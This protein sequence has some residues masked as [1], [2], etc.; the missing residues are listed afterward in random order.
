IIAETSAALLPRPDSLDSAASIADRRPIP[1]VNDAASIPPAATP[2]P[3]TDF[4]KAPPRRPPMVLPI[5]SPDLPA[6]R[7]EA[8]KAFLTSGVILETSGR[9]AIQPTPNSAI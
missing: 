7:S 9:M 6:S 4:F 2:V 1:L 8:P 5:E 3:T